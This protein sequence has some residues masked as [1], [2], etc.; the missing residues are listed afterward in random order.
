MGNIKYYLNKGKGKKTNRPIMINYCFNTQRLRYYTGLWI[1]EGDFNKDSKETPAKAKCIDSIYINNRLTLIRNFI[2]EIENEALGKKEILTPELFKIGLNERLKAKPAKEE[3]RITLM[4]Y[5]DI[6][7]EDSKTRTNTQTGRKLSKAMPIKYNNVKNL[8]NDFCT[9]EG[10]VYDFNDIDENFH[11][12][13]ITY[14]LNEKKYSVNTYGRA[15]KFIKTLLI[16][17]TKAKYN[18]NQYYVNIT[19][20]Q[21][22]SESIYLDEA[23][24]QL[25][26]KLDLSNQPH[27]DRVRDLFIIGCNT[28]L[29]FSDYTTI[30]PGDIQ[31]DRLRLVTQ[32]T[33]AKV[34]IPLMPDAKAI[35]Q[36]Y[37]FQLPK[38]ISNQKFNEYLKQVAEKAGLK[39][40]V[41]THITKGGEAVETKQ[42]K[43][44]LCTS[45]VA[46]RS[47]ATNYYK[48]GVD[49]LQIM[50][51]TGHKT[52]K[53]F[54]KY[55][56]VTGDEKA[57][58]FM[59][60]VNDKQKPK[61]TRKPKATVKPKPQTKAKP[62]ATIKPKS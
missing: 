42:F 23:E 37:N 61:V 22:A 43:Y 35:L 54:Q 60:S 20:A 10:R 11:K 32:K 9:F 28:G 34:I 45:H 38:A 49:T 7:I 29:R 59:K 14:M 48:M 51:I 33:N 40:T 36:K 39:E 13:F 2:G 24:L 46:R 52:E 18:T 15:L 41:I 50:A 4:Q 53:E 6:F 58:L 30:Q 21:E 16:A 31:G 1:A 17:A 26:Y 25:I 8:F 3:T 57:D 27:L 62:K 56:K 19:G 55:I 12:R 5:F 44:E 47:F